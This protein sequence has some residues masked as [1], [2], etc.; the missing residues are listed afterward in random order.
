MEKNITIT[1]GRQFGSGGAEIGEKL[2]KRLGFSY[3]DK[4]LLVRAA[5]ESGL[6]EEAFQKADEQAVDSITYAVPM[7]FP[8]MGGN[9]PYLDVLSKDDFFYFQCQTIENISEKESCVIIGRCADYVLRNSPNCLSFFIHNKKEIRVQRV[10][11]SFKLSVE[12]ATELITKTDKQRSA[13]YNFYT[14]K[15]W[16]CP[17]PITIV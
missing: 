2:A 12:K 16:G 3:Y 8:Y 9:L 13:Y 14:N 10:V 6:C 1:I 4:E 5:E 11:E 15:D 17:L 7:S